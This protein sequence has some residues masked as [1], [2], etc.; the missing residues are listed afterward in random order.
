M[1]EASCCIALVALVVAPGGCKGARQLMPTPNLYAQ[2]GDDPFEG[3]NPALQTTDIDLLYVTDRGPIE[4]PDGSLTYGYARSGS[5]A[6]GKC[7]VQIGKDIDWETLVYQSR[8]PE[9]TIKLPMEVTSITELGRFPPS[10]LPLID[11]GGGELTEDPMVLARAWEI[12]AGLHEE[13]ARRLALTDHKEVYIYV[14]GY[15]NTFY[16]AV[17]TMAELWHFMGRRGVAIAYTWPAGAKGLIRGYN[18]DRES[19]EFTVFHLKQLIRFLA[20]TPELDRINILAHSRG[21]DVTT[22]AVREL[23]IEARG[24]GADPKEAYRIEDIVLAAADLDL[25]VVSQRLTAENLF[26]ISDRLT[27]YVSAK[28]QAIGIADW[29]YKSKH[30]VGRVRYEDLTP[31]MRDRLEY[32]SRSGIAIVDARVKKKGWGHDYFHSNPAVS[33]DL[34]LVWRDDKCPGA[35]NGRPLIQTAPGWW[36]IEAGYPGRQSEAPAAAE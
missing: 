16:D 29:L 31:T 12:A 11:K 22:S 13:I 1:K 19:G 25:E 6:Y 9:R 14:H 35:D 30:R 15:A 20:R 34:I 5:I 24:A 23:L 2:T 3:L 8:A 21:T 36:V 4:K 33:S 7:L 18:R 26:Q 10:P 27:L 28:D 32:I 17:Y